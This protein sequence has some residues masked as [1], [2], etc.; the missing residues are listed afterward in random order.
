MSGSGNWPNAYVQGSATMAW[1][2]GSEMYTSFK[3]LDTNFVHLAQNGQG[4]GNQWW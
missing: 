1:Y 3:G 2:G 4:L